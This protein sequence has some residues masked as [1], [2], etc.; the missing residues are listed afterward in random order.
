MT[1]ARS[2]PQTGRPRR[3]AVS[4]F[5]IS[6]TNAHVVLEHVAVE[7]VE[8]PTA[9]PCPVPVLL[10]GRSEEALRAQA[11]R[12]RQ[13]L[14]DDDELTAADLGRS[15]A[16]GRAGLENRAAVLASTRSDLDNGLGAVAVGVAGPGVVRGSVVEQGGL[17][18]LFTGQGAQRLG[19]GRVLYGSS[20]VFSAAFDAVCGE[21][22]GRLG[23]SVKQVV[24]GGDGELLSRTVFAQAGLFALEV[25]LFRLVERHG[26]RP[27]FL[28][29]HSV[30]EI[31]AAHVAGVLSLSDACELVAAR[32]RLMQA[33]PGGGA[34]VA[35]RA[36]EEEVLPFLSGRVVL[37]AV[38]GPSSVVLSGDEDAVLKVAA[39]WE[40]AGRKVKRLSVGHAFHSHRMD[41]MLDEFRAVVEGLEFH[42]PGVPVVSNVTGAVGS[43]EMCSAE[44]WVRQVR[45]PVRFHD[46]VRALAA[47]G[48]TAWLELGP[49]GVLSALVQEALPEATV[50]PFLRAGRDEA[51]ALS[52]AVAG[53]SVR[54]VAIDWNSFF[55]V[56]GGRVVDLPTYPFQRSRYWLEPGPDLGDATA[57]GLRSANHPLLGA[58]V[59]LAEADGLVLTGKLSLRTHPWLADHT[60]MG[61]TVLPGTA[62]VELAL[63]AG[64]QVG[65]EQLDELTHE[66]PLILPE[67]GELVVQL[68]VGVPEES[69]RR[70]LALH[71]CDGEG[72]WTCHARG[73]LAPGDTPDEHPDLASWPPPGAQAVDVRSFYDDLEGTA[74]RY[75]P[76]FEGLS[77][78]WRRGAELF[79]EVD[80]ARGPS[81]AGYGVHPALLDSGLQAMR[82]GFVNHDLDQDPD[83]AR[84][85]F[86]WTGVRLH[87]TGASS[88]RLRIRR[89]G[90]D[91][92]AVAV[93][94]STGRPVLSIGSLVLRQVAAAQLRGAGRK[95]R[96]GSLHTLTW[97]EAEPGVAAVAP[98]KGRVVVVAPDA[99]ALAEEDAPVEVFADLASVTGEPAVVLASILPRPAVNR[100]A[101]AR[102]VAHRTLDLVQEWL[103]DSRFDAARLV[104]L[105]R[106]AV[107]V[108]DELPEPEAAVVWGLAGSVQAEHPG[109][110][111]LV[112]AGDRRLSARM[113]AT[114]LA[115]GEP[116]LAVR[117]GSVPLVPRLARAD[118]GPAAPGADL[119]AGT[120]LIT[121]G[122]GTLGSAVARHLVAEHGARHLLLISRSGPHA[123][124]AS[125]LTAELDRLGAATV[126]V[127]VCDVTDRAALAGLIAEIPLSRPLTGVVHAAGVVDDGAVASLNHARIDGVLAAKAEAAWHLHELTR[128]RD[129]AF[130]VLSSSIAGLAGSAGQAG[131]AAAN[132]FLDALA[133]R[134]RAEGLTAL[135]LV[136]GPWADERGMAGRLTAASR[137][138]IA[139]HGLRPLATDAALA[140]FDS[141]L[142]QDEPVV[143]ALVLESGGKRLDDVP[144]VF[145]GLLAARTRRGRGPSSQLL[146]R[147]VAMSDA[148]RTVT[149]SALVRDQIAL[150]LGYASSAAVPVDRA[151]QDLGLD[152]LTA[153]ELRNRLAAETGLALPP[154]I[155]FDHPTPDALAEHLGALLA[156]TT[157]ALTPAAPVALSGDPIA[158]IATSCRL[159]GG[160]AT[161]EDLWR[162]V[163]DGVDGISPFPTNRGWD[164]EGVYDPDPDRARTSYAR[165][166][167]FVHD[168]DEFD[169]DFFGIAPREALAMD[170]QQRLLLETA[171]EAF[172]RA[173]ID[174]TSLRG[175]RTGVFVG[176]AAQEYGPRLHRATE[177]VEGYLL[178]GNTASVASGRIAYTFALEGPAVTVDT[179]CSSSLVA[180]H[181]AVQALRRGECSH[182]LVGGVTIMANPGMFVEFSRQRGLAADGRAKSFAAAA[183]GTIWAEGAGML[184]LQPLAE[185]RRDRHRVLAVVRGSAV[186]QDGASNGL[187]APN[188]P[189]QQRVIAQALADGGLTA[190]D[191]DAVEAHGTGTRLGDP[192][193][194]GALLATYGQDRPKDRPLWLGS[195]KSNFGH[196]QAAAGVAGVI[197]M[198]QAL[199]HGVLPKTL[200]VEEPSPNVDWSAGAV[201]LLTEAR[202]WPETGR[203]HRA[204]VSAFGVSGTNAHVILEQGPPHEET[205]TGEALVSTLP[206]VL[207]AR[208]EEALRAQAG[209]LGAFLE[210]RP[211]LPM[212]AVARSLVAT[213]ALFEHRAVA[214]ASG[215]D[216]AALRAWAR[217]EEHEEIVHGGSDAAPSGP[218]FVFP[219]QGSQWVGMAVELLDESPVFAAR[220]SECAA[221][222]APFTDWSLLDVVRGAEGA[223]SLDRVDVVQPALWAVMI[224][225]AELWR[226][227]GVEPAAVVG[228]SQG[229]IAAACVAGI[230]SLADGAK[231][232]ALR[233]QMIGESLAGGGGMAIAALSPQ[234][235][236]DFLT[237]W[238]DCLSLAAANGPRSVVVAGESEALEEFLAACDARGAWANRVAVDYASHSAQVEGIRERLIEVLRGLQPRSGTVPFYSTLDGGWVERTGTSL[239]AE[240]WYRNLRE[241]VQFASAVGA[242]LDEGHRM[243]IEVSPHPVLTVGMTAVAE[244]RAAGQISVAGTLQRDDGGL[245]RFLLSLSRLFVHG[246][247][248][249]WAPLFE[250]A[251]PA[252]VE[253][254]TYAFQRKRYWLNDEVPVAASTADSGLWD[255]VDRGDLAEFSAELGIDPAA[256]LSSVLPAMAAWRRKRTAVAVSDSWRYRI[257]WRPAQG[258]DIAGPTLRGVWV[259]VTAED[260]DGTE[261]VGAAVNALEQAG[262]DA[263]VIRHGS[264]LLEAIRAA[265][266]V[267]GVI[268]LL[269]LA[270]L[271]A[272]H[273]TAA[274]IG[275]L[276]E[277]GLPA[278]LWCLTRSA[279]STGA[280]GVAPDPAGAAMWGLGRVCALEHPDRWGGL[281]DVEGAATDER[282]WEQVLAVVSGAH[283]NEPEAA[284]RTSGVQVRR[285]LRAPVAARPTAPEW[286]AHGTAL[287]T[288]G[289]GALGARTARWLVQ[290]GIEHL[291]LISRR[292]PSAPRAAELVAELED[293]GVTA[294]V[295]AC[296]AADRAQLAS[297]LAS[298]PPDR[299]LTTVVH[300]AAVLGDALIGSLDRDRIDAVLAPKA[301]AALHLHELTREMDLSAFVLFS[302]FTT[303]VGNPGQGA[304]AAANAML[305]AL[306]QR[307]R[308]EGLKATSV[309]WGPWA[310][311]GLAASPEVAAGLSGRGVSML[312][313]NVALEALGS[314]LDRDEPVLAV[315][316]VDWPTYVSELALDRPAR[317]FAE[318][319]EARMTGGERER[320]SDAA[321]RLRERL[322]G[323]S[324]ADRE[325]VLLDL[326][327][328]RAAMV[329]GHSGPAAVAA[330]RAFKDCGFDSLSAV[331][332]R[333]LLSRETGLRLSTTLV[334]DHPTP[335]ALARH[336]RSLMLP[337]AAD[338]AEPV[339]TGLDELEPLLS[340]SDLSPADR[341]R[342]GNRLRVLA[343][344]L[345]EAQS[346]A[347]GQPEPADVD[348]ELATASDDEVFAFIQK[349][350]GI[351]ETRDLDQRGR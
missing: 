247:D 140:L 169:A 101:S 296:D 124:T 188:G 5:G 38:N 72:P 87:S 73:I 29:G 120:V 202:P 7:A 210:D 24:F 143:A 320:R 12:L 80:P 255:A 48:V 233:S 334:F 21:L 286:R 179:A 123:P 84:L 331:R 303:A 158:I 201:E 237:P 240:Y 54:G 351:S 164:I 292:G 182:A 272:L 350:F 242:L 36:S 137:A 250:G 32:G 23:A 314:A 263:V 231:V 145:R 243:M 103:G 90:Q 159:P 288:G 283:A 266:D 329:L 298:I 116:Q 109:R 111:I 108:G 284:V 149:V 208:S 224:S 83:Q 244:E 211:E 86:S 35:V 199:E 1:E 207:S 19:M 260:Q 77:A 97:R 193:E 268:S 112:D 217:G 279:V 214:V 316:E 310:G 173:G 22:D 68:S 13:L 45:M 270:E 25:A 315:A 3:A 252:T 57:L 226:S 249:D 225:L 69:G 196:A 166:G 160:A 215:T 76:A 172:E 349:E 106:G 99:A 139:S 219:G 155:V 246:A 174:P 141:A 131:Y 142:G 221:A 265:R 301:R 11:A 275:V 289:T 152:S 306:A 344:R 269:G 30:G 307:R 94:D 280:D 91:T 105:T 313:P 213:R 27:A 222:L 26:L 212:A 342:I 198:V 227:F 154:T 223:P 136:W 282:T 88:L 293:L 146:H 121:G 59:G 40:A 273:A 234:E 187:T 65:C 177:E 9:V 104:L 278:P 287:V 42:A 309:A 144:P 291:V 258:A 55:A 115:A 305:D 181:L 47:G 75:G 229:E 56:A 16:T 153:V 186:N 220:M 43:E 89:I 337:A 254:P 327:R 14:A 66:A 150:V 330:D 62:C 264:G 127:A 295:L 100:A 322:A 20:S 312:D 39:Y 10:S 67:S 135:S 176:A 180:L 175:S 28:L 4:S 311:G 126:E 82:L 281:I 218:V 256:P 294:E 138:R 156:G 157:E 205:P 326:V 2:W 184:L 328:D 271:E 113:L 324:E 51:A 41:P 203:P 163:V 63:Q 321:A 178:T 92:V 107:A 194:A 348:G 71:S 125:A 161:P 93:A 151:F 8:V 230:L 64:E 185:A 128:D 70:T 98:P 195:L 165:E 333:N 6:G 95:G 277:A 162:L 335:A 239:T 52:A 339:F 261:L 297:V 58:A 49:G 228:H 60:V 236:E 200:H 318:L 197:K 274:L 148:E 308:A 323:L 302:S 117:D 189:S 336:L 304:Y 132:V 285:L 78:A 245:K 79:A 209:R 44:Y 341:A 206:L 61:E 251:E 53:L 133:V 241:S 232:V 343:A 33:L 299:P 18:F 257:G 259:L 300:T 129:L 170:P 50:V 267:E 130:F 183:D 253:L 81:G 325:A 96:D 216:P 37:A 345:S 46:G 168:A 134:R 190:A 238:A 74:F 319:P 167:G 332:L 17:A 317:L 102:E 340:N 110:I 235:C 118:A 191:V 171:W 119:R 122:T 338:P 34:M 276:G 114:V 290:R 192:I 31:A 147:L 248:V 347:I 346:A 85:P 15:L 204:G 262:A